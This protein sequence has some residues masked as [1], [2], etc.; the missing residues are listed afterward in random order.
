[1]QAA[2]P[3]HGTCSPTVLQNCCNCSST[4]PFN[5]PV[6]LKTKWRRSNLCCMVRA[7]RALSTFQQ[8]PMENKGATILYIPLSDPVKPHCQ[9]PRIVNNR[10]G[11]AS[12]LHFFVLAKAMQLRH[13]SRPKCGGDTGPRTSRRGVS[14]NSA[15]IRLTNMQ[16]I[17]SSTKSIIFVAYQKSRKR[18]LQ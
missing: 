7:R 8:H 12:E 4:N 3:T 1:M 16:S 2:V 15:R 5:S 18:V 14:C 17:P 9:P 11:R 6:V 13:P 10:S